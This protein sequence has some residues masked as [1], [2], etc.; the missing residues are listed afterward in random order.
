MRNVAIIGRP[1]VGKSA[2]FNRLAGRQISI[3]H[4]QPGVTRDRIGSICNLGQAPFE[5]TDTGGIGSEPDPDFAE[6][7]REGAFIAMGSADVILF[8]TDS[9]D[10]VTPLDGELSSMI[11]TVAR[12][13]VLVVNKVDTEGH[14]SRSF[15]FSRLGFKNLVTV[16]AAHGRGIGELVDVIESLLPEPEPEL[17]AHELPPLKL[18]L[19]GRPNVGKSSLVNQILNDNRTTVSDIAGTT[20]DTIDV[21]AEYGGQQYILCDTAG[22]RHRSRHNSSVEVFSVMRSEKTIRR[23]D[24][25]ILVIDATSGV[26]TQDKKIAGL[27]QK[28]KKPAIIVLNK[29]DLIEKQTN[30]DPDLLREHVERATAELFFLDY[31]PVVILSALTG[32]NIRRLFT[33][34]EK[35]RQHATRRAGTG[36]LNRVLRAAMERQSPPSRG[37]RRFKLLYAAQAKESSNSQI[38]PPLFVLFVNDPRLLPESY[39]NYLCARIRDQ[40]EYPGLPILMRLRGREGITQDINE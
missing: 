40:W 11:R 28:A 21:E 5:I 33:M 27:I 17:E 12:Q 32:E 9:I 8:V 20:R 24:V 34:V 22:I 29:W 1:N 6:S 3:V 35:V 16:S 13:V 10:G 38:A 30:N 14:E 37:S 18:A 2:L 25:N 4:D 31:A 23:V 19:I 36:E 39:Q 26:T 7:T 15:E